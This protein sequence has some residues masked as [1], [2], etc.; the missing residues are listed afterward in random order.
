MKFLN[1]RDLRGKSSQILKDLSKEKEMIVTSDGKPIAILASVTE[2][3]LENSL[4]AF[5]KARAIDAVVSLQR[6]S[7]EQGTDNISAVEINKEIKA[8]R[9]KR[10][11]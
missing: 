1:V 5:R 9:N 11:R 7:L 10:A 8:V 4:S 6:R 2:A 3:N